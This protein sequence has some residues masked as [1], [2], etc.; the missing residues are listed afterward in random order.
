MAPKKIR[1]YLNDLEALSAEIRQSSE[2][3]MD[4][5]VTDRLE[6]MKRFELNR[7]LVNLLHYVT[8]HM[9]RANASDYD[10]ES[11][12]W[13]LSSIDQATS[14]IDAASIKHV[15]PVLE[16]MVNRTMSIVNDILND[17]RGAVAA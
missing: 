6:L 9:M 15:S 8:I 16:R 17:L 12:R 4:G 3:A 10:V 5:E 13:I 1:Q 14:Q 2:F 7:N 11:E